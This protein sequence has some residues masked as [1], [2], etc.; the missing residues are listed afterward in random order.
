MRKTWFIYF[1]FSLQPLV[2]NAIPSFIRLINAPT[3]VDKATNHFLIGKHIKRNLLDIRELVCTSEIL[4]RRFEKTLENCISWKEIQK[5]CLQAGICE[6]DLMAKFVLHLELLRNWLNE[7][8]K[9][10][11]SLEYPNL[12]ILTVIQTDDIEIYQMTK[13][14]F[15]QNYISFNKQQVGNT[16]DFLQ[17]TRTL[18]WTIFYSI[19]AE[20]YN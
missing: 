15:F 5:F 7:L 3:I 6:I 12:T 13:T 8:G 10:S 1:L 18:S 17:N 19:N 20:I 14:I 11:P 9:V 16:N 2:V 4:T